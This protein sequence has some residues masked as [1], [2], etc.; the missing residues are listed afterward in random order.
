MSIKNNLFYYATSELSQDAI[1][2]YI[3]SFAMEKNKNANKE[4]Y[5][6]A[7]E[8]INLMGINNEEITV[9]AIKKQYR[10]IDV[11][12]EVNEKYNIIIEDKT[13][14][15]QHSDQINRYKQALVDENKKNIICV[16]YKIVEEHFKEEGVINITRNDIL[17]ILTKYNTGDKIIEDYTNYLKWIDEDVNAYKNASIQDWKLKYPNAYRGFFTY[18]INEQ[19]I[20]SERVGGWSYINNPSGGLWGLWWYYIDY[21]LMENSG[22]YKE[23]IEDLY[24]Q[25]SD[26]QITVKISK[27]KNISPEN[28]EILK[29]IRW[30]LYNYFKN[31]LP[32]SLFNKNRFTQGKY[33]TV[34]YIEYDEKNYKEKIKLMEG[35]MKTIED[36]KYNYNYNNKIH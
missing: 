8:L 25:I 30:S 26:N 27:P 10:N 7:S 4:I 22:L 28:L 13:F 3:M 11:L 20:D 33:M 17:N 2:C 35:I 34:G 36:G 29:D 24:L 9:T 31:N 14:T 1:I 6:I 23:Y 15:S 18:L 12:I 5:N 19:I 21:K 16:Y 32:D